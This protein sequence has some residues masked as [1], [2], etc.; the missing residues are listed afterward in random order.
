MGGSVQGQVLSR[1]A[2]VAREFAVELSECQ[3]S[4]PG[5]QTTLDID[6]AFAFHG[7]E[8]GCHQVSVYSL[9]TREVV[10]RQMMNVDG[11]T[12]DLVVDLREA[13]GEKPG[14]GFVSMR[15]LRNPPPRKAR[16]AF[17]RGQR[18]A[19][20]GNS[21]AAIA[22]Y[23]KAIELF[24]DYASAHA[25]LAEQFEKRN[26]PED[27]TKEWEAARKLGMETPQLY[28]GLALCLLETGR[29]EE[30]EQTA[31]QALA[32]DPS[33]APAHYLL[34]VS[35]TS[36]P[37]NRPEAIAH[38]TRAAA[39]L[40]RAWLMAAQLRAAGGDYEGARQEL[41]EYLKACP[42]KE[43]PEV[44]RWMGELQTARSFR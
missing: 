22:A 29:N 25:A 14:H 20:K 17:E 38:F 28:A 32:H 24:P 27:A 19:A 2:N 35:L 23:T 8:S 39:R 10:Y 43:K 42:E 1:G 7:V 21:E 37:K 44:Q 5:I 36:R 34:G 11:N 33:Y 41:G 13:A 15:E 31:R 30:A 6:G 18:D 16:A 9:L 40:P 3:Q 4:G 12:P 26:R